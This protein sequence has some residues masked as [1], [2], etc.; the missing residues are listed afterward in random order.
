MRYTKKSDV[1]SAWGKKINAAK[2][3]YK[4]AGFD[5]GFYRSDVYKDIKRREKRALYRYDNRERISEQKRQYRERVK[6]ARIASPS[7]VAFDGDALKAFSGAA[8]RN[9]RRAIAAIN[10]KNFVGNLNVTEERDGIDVTLDKKKYLS[11]A[12]YQNRISF[13]VSYLFSKSDGYLIFNSTV[14]RL[15]EYDRKTDTLYHTTNIHISDDE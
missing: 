2:S 9:D 14:Q 5:G 3:A 12:A 15:I 8:G 11:D 13:W 7:N 10:A 4:T 1:K 6:S